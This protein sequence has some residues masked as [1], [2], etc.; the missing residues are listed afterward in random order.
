MKFTTREKRALRILEPAVLNEPYMD[1]F[2]FLNVHRSDYK[3][4]VERKK[5]YADFCK[6]VIEHISKTKFSKKKIC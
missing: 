1:F 3:L 4:N 6:H 5:L 2:N